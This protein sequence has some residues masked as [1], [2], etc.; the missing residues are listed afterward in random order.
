MKNTHSLAAMRWVGTLWVGTSLL[1]G[2][3]C[4]N[5]TKSEPRGEKSN[6]AAKTD[7]G[8]AK[9]TVTATLAPTPTTSAAVS[10]SSRAATPPTNATESLLAAVSIDCLACAQALAPT[11][12]GCDLSVLNCETFPEGKKRTQC[13]DT[14]RCVLPAAGRPSCIDKTNSNL[15]SCYCGGVGVED[16]LVAGNAKGRCKSELESGLGSI[17]PGFIARNTTN[18]AEPAGRA[19]KLAKCLA[20]VGRLIDTK[21]QQCF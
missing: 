16:C 15:T 2:A 6:L 17:E 21:C 3:G 13:L 4:S 8:I 18:V 9:P 1:A 12:G 20:E 5:Q 10:A 19:M 7:A 14:L 11:P